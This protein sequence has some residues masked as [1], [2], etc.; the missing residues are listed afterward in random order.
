MTAISFANNFYFAYYQ[1]LMGLIYYN[2]RMFHAHPDDQKRGMK[3]VL[4]LSVAAVLGVGSS[5]FFFFHGAR[6]FFNNQRIPFE[7]DIP[8][9]EPFNENTNLFMTTI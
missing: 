5:L 6:S 4:P 7:G 3:T 2:L 8:F 9:I 1:V